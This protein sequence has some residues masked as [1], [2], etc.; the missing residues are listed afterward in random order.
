M[1]AQ[2]TDGLSHADHSKG[3]MKG[4]NML[5]YIPLH[6]HLQRTQSKAMV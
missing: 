1:I 2:G 5:A 4:E 6:F 3:V